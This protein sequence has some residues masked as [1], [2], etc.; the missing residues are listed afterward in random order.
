MYLSKRFPDVNIGDTVRIYKTDTGY[1]VGDY[2]VYD[3]WIITRHS[4]RDNTE[5]ET[6]FLTVF[7]NPYPEHPDI[8]EYIYDVTVDDITDVVKGDNN[9]D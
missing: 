5:V 4:V 9:G 7:N 2:E 6:K 8:R 1:Y 3:F